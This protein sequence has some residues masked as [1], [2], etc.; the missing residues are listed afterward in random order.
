MI[1][2]LI[3]GALAAVG[4]ASRSAAGTRVLGR[5]W[6]VG[7][8]LWML[9]ALWDLALIPGAPPLGWHPG[10]T[11]ILIEVLGPPVLALLLMRTIAW[12][13]APR[14]LSR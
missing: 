1:W 8:V 7:S 12:V 4:V 14:R 2:L 5:I 3:I 9:A 6:L 10:L 13:I 11:R